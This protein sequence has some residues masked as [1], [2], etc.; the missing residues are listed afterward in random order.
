LNSQKNR[1]LGAMG[2]LAFLIVVIDQMTK[3]I[4]REQLRTA[5]MSFFGDLFR[6]QHA[7]NPGAFMS[8]GDALAPDLRFG[9]FVIGVA[10]F[11]VAAGYFI[12]KK[13]ES[14]FQ[15]SMALSFIFAGGIGN[16]IDR[17]VKG[18]VTDFM[19]I[20]IGS[21]RTGVFNVADMSIVGGVIFL[22]FW[23]TFKPKKTV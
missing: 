13:I 23:T 11:L 14:D 18:S 21:L 7:E 9:L 10:I 22:Y 8:F 15:I 1:R 12:I 17:A 20:G 6:L 16:L 5:P 4:S 19:N 3:S 2:L